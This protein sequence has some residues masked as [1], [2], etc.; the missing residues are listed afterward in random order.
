MIAGRNG[1]DAKVID[2][3]VVD[4]AGYAEA[5]GA[6]FAVDDHNIWVVLGSRFWQLGLKAT[7]AGFAHDIA[8]R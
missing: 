4:F 2:E 8:D 6:I 1:V 5:P 3:L 7:P